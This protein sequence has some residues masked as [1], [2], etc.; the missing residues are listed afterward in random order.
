MLIVGAGLAGLTVAEA[1][2]AEGYAGPLTLLGEEAHPPYHRPP[3]SKG[4]LLGATPQA[5]LAMR[6]PEL[7][8]KRNIALETGT[9]V[10]AIDRAAHEVTLA[11]GSRRAYA[12]L[13]LCT[14]SRPRRLTLPNAQAHG[15]FAL[16]TID[17]AKAIAAAFAQAQ[18]VVIVGG[19][20][21]GLEVAAAARQ[22]GKQVTVLEAL[23]RLMARV[24]APLISQFYFDLH[25]AHGVDIVLGAT[26]G[27]LVVSG[28]RIAAVRTSDG[29][30]FAADVVIVG[31]GIVPNSEIASAAG[32]ECQGGGIVV[33][34]CSR[35][36]DAAIVAAGD[37]TARRLPDGAL[38]RLESIHNAAE[39]AKSAAAA[40][41]GKE[42]EFAA[43][44]W[45]WSE[46]YDVRLQMVGL[47]AGFDAMVMRGD[48]AEGKFSAFYFRQGRLIAADSVNH[49][50]E[51]LSAR[52][53]LDQ[54]LSPRPEL[55][56]DRGLALNS[57]LSG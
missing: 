32:I 24:V 4:Y 26:V 54:G 35:S 33:D 3:L 57:L 11:D 50:G 5:Q 21:I 56:A 39:Q 42:R 23:P 1:L 45:F 2:R 49:P 46:Q 15:V 36:S 48:P 10:T 17:D 20:F 38:R 47:N 9:R 51:H 43:T 7:L 53:L 13:A 22:Q 8:A 31:I 29:R 6:A 44:P 19:G 28:G 16:R 34:A 18:N 25:S 52:K 40:L 14:G 41:L 12:G 27:E 30:Q 37:C 55:L